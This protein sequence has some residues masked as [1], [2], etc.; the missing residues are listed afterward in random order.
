M[1]TDLNKKYQPT[2]TTLKC[3][4]SMGLE[5]HKP[6]LIKCYQKYIFAPFLEFIKSRGQ[7]LEYILYVPKAVFLLVVWLGQIACSSAWWQG[8]LSQEKSW[9]A[10]NGAVEQVGCWVEFMWRDWEWSCCLTTSQV[11]ISPCSL[12]QEGAVLTQNWGC[13]WGCFKWGKCQLQFFPTC[14]LQG[15]MVM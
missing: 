11:L 5:I 7:N 4:F 13:A 8:G 10:L 6:A 14:V 3:R 9:H 1:S 15:G 2:N 12:R